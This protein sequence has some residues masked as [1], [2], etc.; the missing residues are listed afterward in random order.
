MVRGRAGGQEIFSALKIRHDPL[1]LS[2]SASA[3]ADIVPRAILSG[4]A[5]A[6]TG[7]RA[8]PLLGPPPAPVEGSFLPLRAPSQDVAVHRSSHGRKRLRAV[9]RI[10]RT[11]PPRLGG[12]EP[13]PPGMSPDS[14]ARLLVRSRARDDLIAPVTASALLHALVALALALRLEPR[15]QEP[16]PPAEVALVWQPNPSRKLSLPNSGTFK[17]APPAEVRHGS[18]GANAPTAPPPSI[19]STASSVP[20]QQQAEPETAKSQEQKPTKSEQAKAARE[21]R[22][23]PVREATRTAPPVSSVTNPFANLINPSLGPPAPTTEGVLGPPNDHSAEMA[24]PAPQGQTSEG[25]LLSAIDAPNANPNWEAELRAW[26][27]ARDYYPQ[28]AVV[29]HEEGISSISVT[30]DK[31]GKVLDVEVI[32]SSQSDRLDDAWLSVFRN[33]TVPQPTPDMN[34][35]DSYTFQATLQYE[36]IEE[37][38]Q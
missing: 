37:A 9:P 38:A 12:L 2:L 35:G 8:E 15:L 7:P 28:A 20:E 26:V 23:S 32:S 27:E 13:L 22:R 25:N 24:G 33:R 6:S 18:R 17:N 16:P 4:T 1:A 5:D 31:Y 10:R 30:I 34:V 19:P 14:R 3:A 29:K 11:E 21:A 36:L